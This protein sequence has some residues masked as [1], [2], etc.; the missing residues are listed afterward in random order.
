MNGMTQLTRYFSFPFVRYAFLVGLLVALC[1]SLI[2]VI[3]V[4][5]RFSFL[6]DGLSHFA[7][8]VIAVATIAGVTDNMLI[9]MPVTVLCAVILLRTGQNAKIKGDAA[10]AVISVSS[11]A[12]GYLL[13]NVFSASA[14]VSGDV[15]STLF[16]STSM[17]TLTKGDVILCAAVA[18]VMVLFY[19]LFYNRIFA[20]TFDEDFASATGTRA[21]VFNTATAVMAAVVIVLGMKLVGSL[22]ITALIVF[23]A[24]SAMRIFKSFRAVVLCAAAVSVTGAAGGFLLSLIFSTPVGATMAVADIVLFLL[25]CLAGRLCRR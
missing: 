22:L 3:F 6:G 5:K 13:L 9:V 1:A 18:G 24:L 11:L 2:G 23:P 10:V 8:G 19:V 17:L 20:V 21:G 7:F 16:G 15:C 12:V 4:L 25:F 14:N